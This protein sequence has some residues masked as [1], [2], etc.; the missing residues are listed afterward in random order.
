MVKF[1]LINF[2]L[3]FLILVTCNTL[4][5]KVNWRPKFKDVDPKVQTYADQWLESSELYGINFNHKVTIGFANI[6]RPNVVAECEYGLGF[7]EITID[8]TYWKDMDETNRSMTLWHE[9]GHCYCNEGHQF[10]KDH[11]KYNEDGVNPKDGF[12]SDSCPKSFMYPYV[13][14]EGCLYIHFSEYMDDIFQN[15][16]PY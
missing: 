15:C 6:N 16:K 11:K 13:M 7:R 10:G 14:Y 9:M 3:I 1:K 2:L 4:L 5:F 12:F 8:S